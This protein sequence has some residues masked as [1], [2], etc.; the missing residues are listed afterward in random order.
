MNV[1][2]ITEK[3]LTRIATGSDRGVYTSNTISSTRVDRVKIS[4]I[5]FPGTGRFA[6]IPVTGGG[7]RSTQNGMNSTNC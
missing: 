2:W 1:F 6:A 5:F 3:Y 4:N 7:S